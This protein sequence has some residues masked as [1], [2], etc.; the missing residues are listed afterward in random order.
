MTALHA[1]FGFLRSV[2]RGSRAGLAPGDV[3]PPAYAAAIP[4]PIELSIVVPTFNERANVGPLIGRIAAAL[5]GVQWEVIVVD[6]DSPDR[7]ADYV[8]TLHARDPRVRVIRRV[9][10]RGLSSAC[11]EGMLAS[12]APFLAVM[13]ADLQH[14]PALLA[15]MLATLRAGHTDLV[16]GS[17]H[18]A[19]GSLGEW[20][21]SRAAASRLATW[22]ATKMT[23]VDLT[24]PMSGFFALRREV[25]DRWAPELSAIGFKV[26][27]DIVLTAGPSL[28]IRELP[29][30]FSTRRHGES[31][32]SLRVTWDYGMML[33]DRLFGHVIPVRLFSFACV[34][35]LGLLVHLAVLG[36]L[37]RLLGAGFRIS[38]VVAT[39]AA[40]I[41]NYAVN[42]L[43]TY[44]DRRRR[45][46][47]WLGG[48]ASFALVCAIGAIANVLVATTA[49]GMGLPWEMAAIAGIL[50]GMVWN[51]G[52][53]ARY[54]WSTDA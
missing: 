10:R 26:L 36:L 45:G 35:A 2:S 12:S 4:E 6:D 7:T 11:V 27:L 13:D 1:E 16:I 18:V 22:F 37:F 31:K 32:L 40:M 50:A 9:G 8:R 19:G 23:A 41:G 29:L 17:R 15:A 47:G 5:A 39:G 42:N 3:A 43:L 46:W 48:L 38:E 20:A 49:L 30:R 21:G 52:A 14:D 24:D 51:Y 54:T 28:R 53:S 44:A 34:G 33:A 25:I